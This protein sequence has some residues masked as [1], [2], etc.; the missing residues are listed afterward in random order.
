MC[1]IVC[2]LIIVNVK[3]VCGA[4]KGKWRLGKKT[5]TVSTNVGELGNT[6][7]KDDCSADSKYFPNVSIAVEH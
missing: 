7:T 5:A 6:N 4:R 1:N 3:K 2:A